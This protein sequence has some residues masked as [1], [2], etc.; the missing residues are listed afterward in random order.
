M[1]RAMSLFFA[2]FLLGACGQSQ[3]AKAPSPPDGQ[4]LASS[5]QAK[6]VALIE[7]DEDGHASAYCAG[8]WVSATSILTAHHCAARTD[9]GSS[10]SALAVEYAT[11]SDVFEGPW[12]RTVTGGHMGYTYARDEQ[13]DLALVRTINP[14]T[15]VVAP[16][17]AKGPVGVGAAVHTVGH[18][19]GLWWSFSSG[20][21]AS[22]R[23]R[24]SIL[25]IQATPAISPGNSG[26]GL[27]DNGAELV[28]ITSATI[29]RGQNLN[30]FVSGADIQV[31]LQK[32]GPGL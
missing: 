3:P 16:V 17:R 1:V 11:V 24:G 25:R 13:H 15:H 23:P 12:Q 31:F 28:G 4:A 7:R 10:G 29:D 18:P 19:F 14:P 22:I 30:F 32:Q 8:V 5:I 27:F 9:V 6:T 20:N 2:G 26:G 21:V